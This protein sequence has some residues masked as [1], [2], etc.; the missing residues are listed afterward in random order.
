M[1][2]V[3]LALQ[4]S[5]LRGHGLCVKNEHHHYI[6][7]TNAGLIVA[8]AKEIMFTCL[9]VSGNA[10]HGPLDCGSNVMVRV[11]VRWGHCHTLHGRMC[12]TY[13][14][15]Y[16]NLLHAHTDHFNSHFLQNLS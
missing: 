15:T 13:N 4:C 12:V 11:M 3:G 7:H 8:S 6:P 1:A 16:D 2:T 10:S 9:S 14:R 5:Q